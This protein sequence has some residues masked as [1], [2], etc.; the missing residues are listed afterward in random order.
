MPASSPSQ[1]VPGVPRHAADQLIGGGEARS[2]ILQ[3]FG[4]VRGV[5]GQDEEGPVALEDDAGVVVAT[6]ARAGL[7]GD[8]RAERQERRQ[9]RLQL[10]P[11]EDV[12][13][14]A[15]EGRRA[16]KLRRRRS[17]RRAL[18]NLLEQETLVVGR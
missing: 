10:L 17:V 13:A 5:S 15:A 12:E 1:I 7:V 3:G 11:R 18:Q 14:Q 8:L 16:L 2:A 9:P 4:N 6:V